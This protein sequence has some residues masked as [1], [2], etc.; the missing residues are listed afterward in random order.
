MI[1]VQVFK[2]GCAVADYRYEIAEFSNKFSKKLDYE[3]EIAYE[4]V[5]KYNLPIKLGK[6]GLSFSNSNA[7][8]K[9]TSSRLDSNWYILIWPATIKVRVNDSKQ[10]EREMSSLDL[11]LFCEHGAKQ[12]VDLFVQNQ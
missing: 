1:R 9:Y 5:L 12:Y 10:I 11:A 8:K 6:K 4:A 2:E 7:K 3:R